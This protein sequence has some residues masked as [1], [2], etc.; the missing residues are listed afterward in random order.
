M[1]NV[2]DDGEG[3]EPSYN[4][5]ECQTIGF[6]SIRKEKSRNFMYSG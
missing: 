2:G 5:P 1:T 4:L 6:R 3:M